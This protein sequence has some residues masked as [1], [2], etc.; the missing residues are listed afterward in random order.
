MAR[1]ITSGFQNEIEADQLHPI[2]LYKAE[3]V[4][5]DVRFW[6]GEGNITYNSE[7]Y[8]GSSDLITIEPIEETQE[9]V[10]NGTTFTLS[11]ID[12]ALTALALNMPTEGQGQPVS[13]QFG[14]LNTDLSLIA[15]P[16]QIFSGKMDVATIK[17]DGSTSKIN[18]TAENDFLGFKEQKPSYYT[19]EDQKALFSGD[20][21]LDFVPRIQDIELTWGAG[22]DD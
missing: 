7:V 15:D 8:L 2:L 10:A 21:G 17:D 9:I 11:G 6:T 3:F 13:C 20:L 18:V 5:G 16:Y 22:R 4:S 19:P 1:D 14:V 12:T